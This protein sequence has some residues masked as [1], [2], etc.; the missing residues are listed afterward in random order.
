MAGAFCVDGRGELQRWA[1]QDMLAGGRSPPPPPRRWR[2]RSSLAELDTPCSLQGLI[3]ARER[4]LRLGCRGHRANGTHS[5]RRVGSPKTATMASPM[6]FSIVPPC[7]S[8]S[9]AH[10]VEVAGQN[11][12]ER[13]RIE[14]LAEAGRTLRDPKVTT[15]T[16]R[17]IS[18]GGRSSESS[19][20]TLP[21]TTGTSMGFRRGRLDTRPRGESRR[22][23]R[24]RHDFA[25]RRRA[26]D[27][28][29][30]PRLALRQRI[31]RSS[32]SGRL[33]AMRRRSPGS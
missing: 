10:L 14:L 12:A 28:V 32:A 20:P 31:V 3:E 13:L 30:A 15:V 26:V 23:R 17:R 9:Q 11:L 33:L 27:K 16:I 19:C 25:R 1:R 22:D 4:T 29:P 21:G 8:R 24:Q 5:S 2:R 7:D 6:I 18:S